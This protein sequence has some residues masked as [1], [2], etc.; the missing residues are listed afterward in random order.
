[1]TEETDDG[2]LE[3]VVVLCESP[4]IDGFPLDREIQNR[5]LPGA[6]YEYCFQKLIMRRDGTI[7]FVVAEDLRG[8]C[9]KFEGDRDFFENRN[10]WPQ[11]VHAVD[12]KTAYDIKA[13]FDLTVM[14][15]R[16][17][18]YQERVAEVINAA[19]LDVKSV[20]AARKACL[21]IH[22]LADEEIER[23]RSSLLLEHQLDDDSVTRQRNDMLV[24]CNLDEASID[25]RRTAELKKH[26]LL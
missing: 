1:M 7:A 15:R 13:W 9:A 5:L 19:K 8:H 26:N 21:E 10:K 25:E 11:S 23:K 4:S 6:R 24:D 16:H 22:G 3:G 2:S 12:A 14:E 18:A 20:E 17:R